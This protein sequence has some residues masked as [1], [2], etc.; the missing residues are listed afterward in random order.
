MDP[1]E[2]QKAESDFEQ[3]VRNLAAFRAVLSGP[4]AEDETLQGDQPIR[5][6]LRDIL[7]YFLKEHPEHEQ[8]RGKLNDRCGDE[9]RPIKKSLWIALTE[10]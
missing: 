1:L 2:L 9:S 10:K 6:Q 5:V 3:F 7:P 8:L 4:H